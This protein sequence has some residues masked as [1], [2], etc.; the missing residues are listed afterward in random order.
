MRKRTKQEEYE[1]CKERGHQG[2]PLL[3]QNAVYGAPMV[4]GCI[5]CGTHYHIK[6]KRELVEENVPE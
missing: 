6:E 2:E 5:W 1:I 3:A 4:S